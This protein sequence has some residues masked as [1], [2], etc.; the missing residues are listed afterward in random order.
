MNTII[1]MWDFY[2]E[3]NLFITGGSGFLGT[4]LIYRLVTQAPAARLY[5]LCRGG[6]PYVDFLSTT[7]VPPSQRLIM[8]Q[9]EAN[10]NMER[11]PPTTSSGAND[12]SKG[13]FSA[14]WRHVTARL[15]VDLQQ[16]GHHSSAG[17]CDHSF[18]ILNRTFKLAGQTGFTCDRGLRASGSFCIGV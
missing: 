11:G 8:R 12:R 2:T 5:I 17:S 7:L 14:G 6:L 15:W 13:R 10:K 1:K 4:A 18:G 9:Q 16:F 3:K